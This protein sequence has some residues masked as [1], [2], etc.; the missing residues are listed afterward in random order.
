MVERK[1]EPEVEIILE[2]IDNGENFL[3]SGGA[4]SG[5]TFSLV[6]VIKK[7]IEDHPTAKIATITYTNAA[8]KEIKE[9]VNHQNLS[10]STIHDFLWDNIK[11]YQKELKKGLISLMK[12]TQSK[13]KSLDDTVDLTYFDHLLEGIQYK[14]YTRIKEGIIS[15]DEVLELANYM[16]KS[17]PLLGDILKDKYNFIFIDE[18]QDT[19]S[20]VI[21]IFL[22]HLKQSKK[23]NTIGFFGDAM[24]SIYKDGIGDLQNYIATGDV[25]EVLKEQNRRNPRMVIELANRLRTDGLIQKP[26]TDN[27]APNM[28]NGVVKEGVIK[29][30]YSFNNDLD[31]VRNSEYF[32][33]WDFSDAKKTKE[34]N[35]THNLI[36]NQAGFPELMAIYDKDPILAL[37]KSILDKIRMNIISIDENQTFDQIVDLVKLQNK[38]RELKKDEIIQDPV[39][40]NLYE[41]VKNLPFNEV[42]KI[43]IDKDSLIDDKKQ[44]ED[45]ENKEG[46]KRDNLI[47]HLF[48]IEDIIQLYK[49]K[50]YNEFIRKT[51]FK[52]TS[53]AKKKEIKDII[54]AID[55]MSND[56]IE[57]VINYADEKGIVKKDDKFNY[58][59]KENWYLF[60]RVKKVKYQEF[61]N[62]Y[63]YLEG[64]TPFSTQHKTKG[65]EYENVLVVL[66]NGGWNDYNFQYLFDNDISN[67][68][69][70]G[71]KKSYPSIL[72]RTQKIFYVCCTRAKDNLIIF[73]H[74]PS[75]AV[76][77]QAIEWFGKNNVHSI[78]EKNS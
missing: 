68:L 13:I 50:K 29:F 66:D 76:I 10:V 12:D 24:Q 40:S 55:K 71:K 21:E 57:V 64:Y 14:E 67:T 20:L 75:D 51:E 17:Y 34:L 1:L 33:D 39:H 61:R 4:G 52:I 62:L 70:S 38:N 27:D 73:Y 7:V 25:K 60:N 15:H 69:S 35:L 53:I 58:F 59:V 26:S 32:V 30:L 36:A 56:E 19:N 43:Y 11:S 16:F 77:N 28:I 63:N 2:H 6:Q 49:S 22:V 37:K 74:K 8:V 23:K 18:Y 42:R 65:A 41:Q 3:L 72:S 48:K 31:A 78:E 44:D 45:D 54:D 5:K 9:R 47:K 46:S